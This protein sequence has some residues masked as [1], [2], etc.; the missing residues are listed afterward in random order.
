MNVWDVVS[1]ILIVCIFG[2]VFGVFLM[3]TIDA[4]CRLTRKLR[5]CCWSVFS[6]Q[7]QY[8]RAQ[9]VPVKVAKVTTAPVNWYAV[10]VRTAQVTSVNTT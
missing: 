4:M 7:T 8:K 2:L 3:L 1:R 5:R 9:I 10:D 6:I